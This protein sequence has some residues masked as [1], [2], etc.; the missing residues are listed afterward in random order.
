MKHT[1]AFLLIPAAVFAAPRTSANYTIA[2]ETTDAAG[3]RATSAHYTADASSGG[4]VGISTAPGEVMKHGYLGQLYEITGLALTAAATVNETAALQLAAMLTLD[5]DT[6]LAL[7][8]ALLAWSVDSGPVTGISLSGLATADVVFADT[9]AIVRGTHGGFTGTHTLTVVDTL[10]DNFGTYAS[11]GLDDAW[12]NQHFGLNNPLAAPT[13]DPDGDA[14]ANLFEFTAGLTPT[15]PQSRFILRLDAVPGQPTQMRA[16]FS[17]LV[18]GRTYTVEFRTSLTS[19]AWAPLT[20]TTQSDA[21]NERTVTD[22]TTET[23]KFYRVN[24]SKP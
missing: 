2:A 8:P 10:P 3:R 19:G 20:G 9:P 6:L 15:D 1:I 5:D 12:Q 4:S 23:Q 7:A 13:A 18:A 14:Q 24:V 11:D 17:P 21:G 16:V 22:T